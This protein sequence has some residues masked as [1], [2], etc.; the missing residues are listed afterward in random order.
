MIFVSYAVREVETGNI[1][2]DNDV[3]DSA[4]E[5]LDEIREFE[6]YHEDDYVGTVMV[7]VI[8]WKAFG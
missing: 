6:K 1:G 8:N 3:V 7:T 2:F 4:F 5:S